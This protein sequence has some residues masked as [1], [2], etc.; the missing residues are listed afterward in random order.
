MVEELAR[1]P[2]L[3]KLDLRGNGLSD[4][5]GLR[6]LRQLREVDASDNDVLVPLGEWLACTPLAAVHALR[7]WLTACVR[8]A[9]WEPTPLEREED[10]MDDDAFAVTTGSLVEVARFSHNGIATIP[11][12]RAPR[13]GGTPAALTPHLPR[14]KQQDLSRH[15]LL[16]EL[17]LDGNFISDMG[18]G[19]RSLQHLR[20]L[21]LAGN[22]IHT[23]T[24][25]DELPLEVRSAA[26]RESPHSPQ[27]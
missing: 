20:V 2:R 12:R 27:R 24:G 26:A 3:Q 17:A 10:E 6:A 16:Q 19:L 11:V 1:F 8:C 13:R 7:L 5:R 15:A 21:S 14:S 4:L 22:Q 9:D 25:L 23:V 18:A